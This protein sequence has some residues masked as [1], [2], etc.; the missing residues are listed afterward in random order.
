LKAKYNSTCQ[1]CYKPIEAG[2]DEIVPMVKDGRTLF[3][4][5][6]CKPL[7]VITE[8]FSDMDVEEEERVSDT[9]TKEEEAGASVSDLPQIPLCPRRHSPIGQWLECLQ[10]RCAWFNKIVKKC[11]VICQSQT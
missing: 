10:E 2:E 6:G 8:D 4:H 9:S 11:G 7:E 1:V 5:E 3:V